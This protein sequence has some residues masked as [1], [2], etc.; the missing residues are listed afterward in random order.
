[1]GLR[2]F[3][4]SPAFVPS[5]KELATHIRRDTAETVLSEA[6]KLKTTAQ[7]QRFMSRQMAILAPDLALLDM[8]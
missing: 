7:V 3:S 2:R 8:V 6:L 4:M 5:I 1:M